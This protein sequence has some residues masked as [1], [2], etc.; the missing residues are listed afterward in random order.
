MNDIKWQHE[1][2]GCDLCVQHNGKYLDVVFNEPSGTWTAMYNGQRLVGGFETRDAARDWLTNHVSNLE[3]CE[4]LADRCE[5]KCSRWQ[6]ILAAI[7]AAALG[8]AAIY[9]IIP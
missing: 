9:K 6:A 1:P 4:S 8:L 3:Y 2:E 5:T 7:L